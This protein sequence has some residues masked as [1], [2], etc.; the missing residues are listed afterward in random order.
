MR[1]QFKFYYWSITV[2][3][4][5]SLLNFNIWRHFFV[6]IYAVSLEEKTNLYGGT[7]SFQNTNISKRLS[8]KIYDKMRLYNPHPIHLVSNLLLLNM[9]PLLSRGMT[10][11]TEHSL[12][13]TRSGHATC[14][15]HFYLYINR[16]SLRS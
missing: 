3:T 10:G 15:A 14:P 8:I 13:W 9:K 12:I 6:A 5:F 1:G 7:E 11:R 16:F 2:Y 4:V